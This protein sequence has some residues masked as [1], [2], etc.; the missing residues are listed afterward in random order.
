[1]KK[2]TAFTKIDLIT[3]FLCIV[4]L[5]LNLGVIGGGARKQAKEAL[6]LS[7][8]HKWGTFFQAYANDYDGVLMDWNEYDWY[9]SPYDPDEHFV[10]AAWVPMMYWYHGD[11]DFC[12]CPSATMGW[13]TTKENYRSPYIAW[14]FRDLSDQYA[15]AS[16]EW[17]PYYE[18]DGKFSYGSYGKNSWVSDGLGWGAGDPYFRNIYIANTNEIPLFGDCNI[19]IGFPTWSDEPSDI[20]NHAPICGCGGEINRWNLDRHNKAINMLF[21]DWSARKVGLRELWMLKWNTQQEGPTNAPV[22]PWGNTDY[23]PDPDNPSDWPEWMR[24]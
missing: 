3:T 11:F 14:D 23:V 4:F 20:K 6:C 15:M 7:R 18:V 21:L 24:D 17:Y 2:Q 19:Y 10:E 1:M 16:G 9:E 12:L 5:I 8:L 22:S 13:S